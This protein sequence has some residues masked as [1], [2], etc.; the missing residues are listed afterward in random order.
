MAAPPRLPAEEAP[1]M[2]QTSEDNTALRKRQEE[3][4]QGE[5]CWSMLDDQVSGRQSDL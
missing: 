2:G 3:L 4:G 5:A 1:L